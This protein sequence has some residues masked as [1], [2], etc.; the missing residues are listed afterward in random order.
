MREKWIINLKIERKKTHRFFKHYEGIVT[1]KSRNG[2]MK[3]NELRGI[4][5][6]AY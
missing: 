6:G 1:I 3:L 5:L 4:D 2:L